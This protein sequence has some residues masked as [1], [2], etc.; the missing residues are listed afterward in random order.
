M[1]RRAVISSD[2]AAKVAGVEIGR[3]THRQWM[4]PR[5]KRP[6]SKAVFESPLAPGPARHGSQPARGRA[7][8]LGVG[9]PGE[10]PNA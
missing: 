1:A 8:F 5:A 10:L 6:Q 9:R 7:S 4:D 3:K 2:V